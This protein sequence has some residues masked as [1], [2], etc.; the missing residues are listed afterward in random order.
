MRK[1]LQ[2]RFSRISWAGIAGAESRSGSG[3]SVAYTCTIRAALPDLFSAF[4]VTTFVDA[5]C[6]DWNWMQKVDLT[7]MTYVGLDI[8]EDIVTDNQAR[9]S[10][11]GV[12][13]EV[14]D[15]TSDPLPAGDL[16]MARDCLFH[17]DNAM[18]WAFLRNFVASRIPFLLTTSYEFP[19]NRDI[20]NGWF[21]ELNLCAAPFD[22]G[23]PIRKVQEPE[24]WW[25]DFSDRYLG[26]WK[27]E[28]VQQ[29]LQKAGQDRAPQSDG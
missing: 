2:D 17:L 13:F 14:A 9:F 22:L 12:R 15:I 28:Q 3:S 16:L 29:A 25:T 26:V 7:G 1:E 6:G 21:R 11:P 23:P 18:V 27:R 5:A 4:D 20:E 10:H 8:V 24:E 19:V